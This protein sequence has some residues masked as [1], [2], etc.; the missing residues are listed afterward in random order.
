M[1]NALQNLFGVARM[2]TYNNINYHLTD[3]GQALAMLH[4][5]SPDSST[6]TVMFLKENTDCFCFL[7]LRILLLRFNQF[8]CTKCS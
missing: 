2:F 4:A 8:E 3:I 1:R 7:G 5:Y 6:L